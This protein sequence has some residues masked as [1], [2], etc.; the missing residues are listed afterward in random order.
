MDSATL[1]N[2]GLEFIEAMHLF[3]VEP[4]NIQVVIHPQSVIHSMVEF[5]DGTVMAQM[6]V[7]D[8]ELPIQYALTYPDRK[9]SEVESLD[10][11]TLRALT[12]QKPDIINFPC[13]GLAMDCARRG[14]TAPAVMSAA[15]EV[16]VG[17][18]LKGKTGFNDIYDH[19]AAA[20][21]S[22]EFIK[23]PSLDDIL[24]LDSEAREFVLERV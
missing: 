16:A 18:F 3:G 5:T 11:F 17:L 13:L 19:V 2:K 21:D 7:P 6:A 23:S 22:I 4:E 8:M 20:V 24:E 10:V 14:G 15:N 9:P 1:M 12:F